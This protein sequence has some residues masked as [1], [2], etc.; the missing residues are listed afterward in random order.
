MSRCTGRSSRHIRTRIDV[1]A[2]PQAV[3]FYERVGFRASGVA[4][5]RFGSAPRMSLALDLA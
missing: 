5:T 1:F 4:E 2:N 3:A